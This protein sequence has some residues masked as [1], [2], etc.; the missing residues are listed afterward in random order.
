MLDSSASVLALVYVLSEWGLALKRRAKGSES[1][2]QDRG[3]L[4]LLWI[5]I[6]TSVTMSFEIAHALPAAGMG[7]DAFSPSTLPLPRTIGSSIPDPI[8]LS[9]IRHIQVL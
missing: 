1:R 6:V 2:I 4:A 3:S 8:G 7:A 5:V 9:G